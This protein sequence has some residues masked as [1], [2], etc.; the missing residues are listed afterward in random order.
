M[1]TTTTQ[2]K[3]SDTRQPSHVAELATAA[4]DALTYLDQQPDASQGSLAEVAQ[5]GV[6]HQL[7]Q[8]LSRH[9]STQGKEGKL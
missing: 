4:R 6:R 1:S 3:V 5:C 2:V 9:T 8:A 7:R